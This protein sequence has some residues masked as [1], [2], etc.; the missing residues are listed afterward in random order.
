MATFSSIFIITSALSRSTLAV[1]GSTQTL[2]LH[3]LSDSG[4]GYRVQKFI[5]TATYMHWHRAV[6]DAWNFRWLFGKVDHILVCMWENFVSI[7][8]KRPLGRLSCRWQDNFKIVSEYV[9]CEDMNW[10]QRAQDCWRWPGLMTGW[11]V[12]GNTTVEELLTSW[13]LFVSQNGFFM[14]ICIM[15]KENNLVRQ[16]V[17]RWVMC[18]KRYI[19]VRGEY[20]EVDKIRNGFSVNGCHVQSSIRGR[21]SKKKRS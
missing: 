5:L 19:C 17:N 8:G 7:K 9:D 12:F 21:L 16:G 18:C 6:T 20:L 1:A 4:C 3:R 10:I 2:Q 11:S 14:E 13:Q 15:R